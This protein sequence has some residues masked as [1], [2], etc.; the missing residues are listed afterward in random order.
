[1][2]TTADTPA[3][4]QRPW[5]RWAQAAVLVLSL[6]ALNA[7]LQSG[8]IRLDLTADSRY[9]LSEVTHTTLDSLA[10][11]PASELTIRLYTGGDFPPTVAR[12]Q[13][14]VA[15]HL[16]ELQAY[17]GSNVRVLTL[18]PAQDKVARKLL[19]DRGIEPTSIRVADGELARREVLFYPYAQLTYGSQEAWI[20]LLKGTA[21]ERDIRLLLSAEAEL[22]YKF[23]AAIRRLVLTTQPT[24]GILSGHGE[25]APAQMP[26]LMGELQ[27]HYRLAQVDLKLV[28]ALLPTVGGPK[29]PAARLDALIVP[30][31]DTPLSEAEKF[32][33]DQYLLHGGRILWLIDQERLSERDLIQQGSTLTSLRQ[34]NLDDFFFRYGVKVNY[35]LVQDALC[36]RIDAIRSVGGRD[37]TTQE[38]WLY[39]PLVRTFPVHPVTKNLD[40]VLLRFASTLDTTALSG[41]IKRPILFA[42]VLSRPVNG[43]LMIEFNRTLTQPPPPEVFRG[44]GGRMLGVSLEGRFRSLFAGRELPEGIAAATPRVDSSVAEGRMIIFGDGALALGNHSRA[45]GVGLPADNETLLLNSLDWL[46]GDRALLDIRA[47]DVKL[48][49]LDRKKVLGSEAL[50]RSLALGLP[51]LGLAILGAALAA[52]RRR[53]FGRP[54]PKR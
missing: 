39:F 20:D 16:D 22:E 35:D 14:A 24:I 6:V 25:Y 18:D 44:K 30:Q 12:F 4:P 40:A 38:Q 21:A 19:D 33:L 23:T 46:G 54:A 13:S 47:R 51:L 48:R 45:G 41:V 10:A 9:T 8:Y 5:P 31:P 32:K 42:S 2:S 37:Q 28:P 53:R 11:R 26:E 50:W 7:A 15:T 27:R 1:M 34:T 17:A 52:I 36:G 49:T 43:T 29:V 3:S